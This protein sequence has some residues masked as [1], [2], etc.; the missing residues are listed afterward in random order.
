[1]P[2][3]RHDERSRLATARATHRGDVAG[4]VREE[5]VGV[6][7]EARG[8]GDGGGI[9]PTVHRGSRR[10]DARSRDGRVATATW[11]MKVSVRELVCVCYLQGKILPSFAVFFEKTRYLV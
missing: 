11:P 9:D 4:D 6:E 2:K 8:G 10:G 1:V 7:G 5:R 3:L